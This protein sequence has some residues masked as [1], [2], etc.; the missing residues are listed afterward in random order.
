[1][2]K[3]IIAILV[4]LLVWVSGSCGTGPQEEE[5]RDPQPVPW[6]YWEYADGRRF[7]V[8][9]KDSS[10]GYGQGWKGRPSGT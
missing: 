2:K 9:D 1:M 8:P 5:Q 6:Q 7:R 3:V 4:Q 10:Q